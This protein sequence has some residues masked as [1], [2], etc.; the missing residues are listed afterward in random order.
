MNECRVGVRSCLQD[1]KEKELDGLNM[2]MDSEVNFH[3]C[4]L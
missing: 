1:K 4:E 3:A 2:R